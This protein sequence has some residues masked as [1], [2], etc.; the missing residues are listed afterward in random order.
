MTTDL[1]SATGDAIY[2]HIVH[3]LVA[4]LPGTRGSAAKWVG[5]GTLLQVGKHVAVLT[6]AHAAE[7]AQ[8]EEYRLAWAGIQQPLCN[9]VAGVAL[10]PRPEVDVGLLIVKEEHAETLRPRCVSMDVLAG[11]PTI[12]DEDGVGIAGWPA[13]LCDTDE[14]RRRQH[15]TPLLYDT[16]VVSISDGTDGLRPGLHLHW[17]E[18]EGESDQMPHPRGISGGPVW[19]FPRAPRNEFWSAETGRIIG[20][21]VAYTADRRTQRAAAVSDWIDWFQER[22]AELSRFTPDEPAR[23]R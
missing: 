7:D 16:D 14:A 17:G 10:H 15:L 13:A 22:A 3:S 19:W 8:K 5:S 23:V 12:G 21:A 9:F 18:V 6:A 11:S 2:A 20:V 4:I 1:R